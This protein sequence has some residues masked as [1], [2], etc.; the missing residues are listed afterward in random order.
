MWRF[1]ETPCIL[2]VMIL[3]YS[4]FIIKS[5]ITFKKFCNALA[6]KASDDVTVTRKKV[7]SG[8]VTRTSHASSCASSS[9]LFFQKVS[10]KLD[11]DKR[12]V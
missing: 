2:C 5:K 7:S 11:K 6:M 1:F 9:G 8:M 10:R 3:T 4:I 12:K